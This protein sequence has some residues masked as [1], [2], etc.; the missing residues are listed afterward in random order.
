MTTALQPLLATVRMR[1]AAWLA[2]ADD[3]HAELLAMVWGSRFDREHARG[4]VAAQPKA[5][6]DAL[7]SLL[8]AADSFDRL[9]AMRQQRLRRLIWRH[10]ERCDNRLH[11][12]H[13]AD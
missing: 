1:G 11:A 2:T 9:S 8:A 3:P 10:R 5:A 12:T 4:L 6:P 13:P 7:Q